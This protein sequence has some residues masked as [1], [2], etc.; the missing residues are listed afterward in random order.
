MGKVFI[1][2][3]DGVIIDSEPIHQ[4]IE[5]ETAAQLGVQLEPERLESYTGMRP[6]DMWASIINEEKLKVELESVL[7]EV[8][9]RKV[10]AIGGSDLVPI[11]GVVPLLRELKRNQYL[12]A[13]ASSSAY[14]LI[15]AVL[16][17]FS[18]HHYFDCIVSGDDIES[19]KPAP[20]IYLEAAEQLN[21]HP[22]QCTALEDSTNGVSSANTAGMTTIGYKSP[23]AGEQDVS[24]ADHVVDHINKVQ[25]LL[26]L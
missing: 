22:S 11:P 19:G 4:K 17:K 13:V 20:D 15:D 21:V 24:H 16:R 23:E 12:I 5:Q 6:K 3:M 2:D 9:Q 25:S 10:E 7:P 26:S 1:F 14:P 8:E 18:I